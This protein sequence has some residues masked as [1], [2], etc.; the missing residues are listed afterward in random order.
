MQYF[1][2]VGNGSVVEA[3]FALFE[4]QMEVL[5]GDAVVTPQMPLRLVPEVLNSI[6]M[7]GII[8]KQF[9]VVYPVMMELGHVQHIIGHEAV[10]INDA[11]RLY[12]VLNNGKKCFG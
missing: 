9:R 6:D 1:V 7:V 3:P 11:V 2:E 5:L 10:R 4:E 8:G 12:L